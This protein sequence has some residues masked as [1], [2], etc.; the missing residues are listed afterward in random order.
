MLGHI[1][2]ISLTG[3]V[4][5]RLQRERD[6]TALHLSSLGAQTRVFLTERYPATDNVITSLSRW[7]SST[8]TGLGAFIS[9]G[10]FLK[11]LQDH[12]AE[13]DKSV[14]NV[15][16]E[17]EFYS[18]TIKLFTDWLYSSIQGSRDGTLWRSLVAY[19]LLVLSKEQLGIERTLGS[20]F[21]SSGGFEEYEHYLSCLQR[22]NV[23]L[24]NFE[25]SQKFS[26]IVKEVFEKAVQIRVDIQNATYHV[27][28]MRALITWQ[29]QT[30]AGR[31]W[32][33]GA[34][35][36]DNMTVLIDAMYEVQG[37]LAAVILKDLDETFHRDAEAI[38]VS[39]SILC[40]VL[41]ISPIIILFTRAIISDMQQYAITL[42]GQTND[43]RSER[44]RTEQLLYQMM[45]RPIVDK[46]KRNARVTAET[47]SIASV[48]FSDVVGF[49]KI[50][51]DSTPMQV[52]Q[53]FKN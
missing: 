32:Q 20:V 36:F 48:Y 51:G 19:Q 21:F 11:Y 29:Q 14:T 16:K 4:I 27:N 17:I 3:S 40:I 22:Y 33:S 53:F 9:K 43:L 26:P 41:L 39:I 8:T 52:R 30:V 34:W 31:S 25:A 37:Q 1:S 15:Y 13:I 28:Q 38:S 47:F 10:K 35:W 6:M 12:I 45:P 46:L 7:P 2:I 5:H 18:N 44:K 23:G 50:L 24:S 42:A 49:M